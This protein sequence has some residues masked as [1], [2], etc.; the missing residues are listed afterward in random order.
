LFRHAYGDTAVDTL[1]DLIRE[2]EDQLRVARRDAKFAREDLKDAP[3]DRTLRIRLDNAESRASELGRQVAEYQFVAQLDEWL[4]R[5]EPVD[6]LLLKLAPRVG[7]RVDDE[8]LAAAHL[9]RVGVKIPKGWR[10]S[11]S[12]ETVNDNQYDRNSRAAAAA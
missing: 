4:S 1:Q 12:G 8:W 6:E 11:V 3:K 10:S 7:G 2:T 9:A 5:D